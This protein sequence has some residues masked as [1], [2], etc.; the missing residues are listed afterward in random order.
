MVFIILIQK[1]LEVL[2]LLRPIVQRH[3]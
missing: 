2:S 1:I 3:I